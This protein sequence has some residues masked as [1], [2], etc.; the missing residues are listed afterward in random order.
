M[1]DA[2]APGSPTTSTVSGTQ[3]THASRAALTMERIKLGATVLGAIAGALTG[4]WGFYEKV[5]AEARHD[6]AASY[7]TLAPQVNQ[8]GEALKQLQLENQQ[9]RGIVAEHSKTPRLAQ[10]PRRAEAK[11]SGQAAEKPAAPA[12]APVASSPPAPAPPPGAP[13]QAATPE[14]PAEPAAGNDPVSGLLQTVGRTR[15]AIEDLRKVPDDFNRVL[16]NQRR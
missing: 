14:A 2:V 9:L 15:A 8:L 11:P 16:Q 7:N 13:P 4:L 6:T 12:A 3:G 1:S 10:V 5:R